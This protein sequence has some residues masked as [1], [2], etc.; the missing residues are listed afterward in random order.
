V[1]AGTDNK[2]IMNDSMKETF[3]KFQHTNQLL[4]KY[5]TAMIREKTNST[6][7]DE[8]LK[9]IN[10]L[11]DKIEN[12]VMTQILA[13]EID[14][15]S[16]ADITTLSN[17]QEQIIKELSLNK[18]MS[19][20]HADNLRE[21]ITNRNTIL[22]K[23]NEFI[24]ASKVISGDMPPQLST[25]STPG[26]SGSTATA[27]TVKPP[28]YTEATYKTDSEIDSMDMDELC[29][30]FVNDTRFMY[31]NHK[32]ILSEEFIKFSITKTTG[33][34]YT[35]SGIKNKKKQDIV[36][37]YKYLRDVMKTNSIAHRGGNLAKR[38]ELISSSINT[39]NSSGYNELKR[40]AEKLKGNG[41]ITDSLYNK[42]INSIPKHHKK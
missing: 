10:D 7:I 15:T 37:Q 13:K 12:D 29:R 17:Q 32:D 14:P 36:K 33:T 9:Q 21:L 30:N 5:A 41:K 3:N 4:S 23:M 6:E 19:S 1:K 42:Y 35:T 22:D 2:K 20:R 28:T 26:T 27:T 34:V 24:R 25:D 39:G 38:A 40:I 8:R 11:N 18:D 31:E 16:M